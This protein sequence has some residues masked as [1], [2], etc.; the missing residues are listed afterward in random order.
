MK[1]SITTLFFP[2]DELVLCYGAQ[3]QS[4]TQSE[5]IVFNTF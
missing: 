5:L 4:K 3:L 1:M 2:K